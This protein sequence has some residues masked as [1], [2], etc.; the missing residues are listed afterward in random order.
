MGL[1]RTTSFALATVDISEDAD[2]STA[3]DARDMAILGIIVPSTLN[4]TGLLFHVSHDNITYYPLYDTS[5]ALVALTVTASSASDLPVEL[6]PWPWF[7][8]E[9]VTDQ[10]GTDTEFL[11]AM[12]G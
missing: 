7:K 4:G 8:I 10:A 2:L 11:I 1:T 3:V 12:K 6:A 9:T 5:N